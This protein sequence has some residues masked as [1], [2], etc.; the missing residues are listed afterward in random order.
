VDDEGEP[1]YM[2][3]PEWARR[4]IPPFWLDIFKDS[5][6]KGRITFRTTKFI[7]KDVLFRESKF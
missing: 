1:K 4:G 6:E 3:A 2:I 5:C 7:W